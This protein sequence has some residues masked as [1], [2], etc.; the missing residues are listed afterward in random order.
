MEVS[1]ITK[2]ISIVLA[3]SLASE[4]LV[5]ILKT[6]SPWLAGPQPPSTPLPDSRMERVRKVVVML[7]SFFIGWLMSSYSDGEFKIFDSLDIGI[8]NFKIPYFIIGL[9]A[10]GGSAFWT[11]ILS[12]VKAVRDVSTQQN[13]QETLKTGAQLSALASGR[14]DF[15]AAGFAS[16]DPLSLT[17]VQFDATFSGGAGTLKVQINGY[18]DLDFSNNG[19]QSMQLQKGT[20]NYAISGAASNG[21]GGGV[22]LTISGSGVISDSPLIYPAGLILPNVHAM[23]IS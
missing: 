7:I 18:P 6:I 11:S 5:S 8:N 21:P 20:V 19:S 13:V 14:K 9:M 16:L 15:L 2:L 4:R 23:L 22:V 10:S 12:Y 1:I 3:V 17:T